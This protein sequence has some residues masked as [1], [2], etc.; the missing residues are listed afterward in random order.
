MTIIILG[1]SMAFLCISLNNSSVNAIHLM[2][3]ELT[4]I[5]KY[6]VKFET[7]KGVLKEY[8]DKI[9]EFNHTYDIENTPD[10]DLKLRI[11]MPDDKE[12][13]VMYKK[14]LIAF[15]LIIKNRS[16]LR[17]AL[18]DEPNLLDKEF[19]DAIM[20]D[21]VSDTIIN[22]N[23]KKVVK[24]FTDE[25]YFTF[26]RKICDQYSNY[27]EDFPNDDLPTID[28]LYHSYVQKLKAKKKVSKISEP[29]PKLEVPKVDNAKVETP[30]ANA[31]PQEEK[32][33][34]N[35]FLLFEHPNFF[36]KYGRAI[37]PKK[38]VFL[39]G[40]IV[41]REYHN[42]YI[43]LYN[44]CRRCFKNPIYYPYNANVSL[45]LTEEF[46]KIY[47]N[48]AFVLVYANDYN[49][50]LE[51][52]INYASLNGITVLVLTTDEVIETMYKELF[53]DR[54]T[55]I[56]RPYHFKTYESAKMFADIIAG[57]YISAYK[58]MN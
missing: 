40:G 26:V 19:F 38:P 22:E 49:A 11:F 3:G 18:T 45:P 20:D 24:N 23:L 8:P 52:K 12:R 1:G 33:T 36:K 2:D 6:T 37:N 50:D 29:L 47:V 16:F 27:L 51:A 35:P 55:V 7:A 48:S 5:D 10:Y 57:L 15:R 32:P 9:K 25:E 39:F 28:S 4:D 14:H 56:I 34:N 58:K 41:N 44:N 21:A 30:S 54:D 43:E 46:K 42:D 17:Y 53:K 13:F 31:L